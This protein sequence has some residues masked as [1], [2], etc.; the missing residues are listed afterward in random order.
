MARQWLNVFTDQAGVSSAAQWLKFDDTAQ[1]NAKAI[2]ILES[3]RSGAVIM[4]H[5]GLSSYGDAE[6]YLKINFSNGTFKY[7]SAP[8]HTPMKCSTSRLSNSTSCF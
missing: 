8:P 6:V 7:L 5:N 1:L 4:T 3:N 2:R